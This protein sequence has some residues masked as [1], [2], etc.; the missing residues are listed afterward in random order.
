MDKVKL[1]GVPIIQDRSINLWEGMGLLFIGLKLT[2]H[3]QDWNWYQVTAPLW[4][5]FV[6]TLILKLVIIVLG[7]GKDEE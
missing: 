2:D 3:L 4:V 5:P 7:I 6:L 1:V